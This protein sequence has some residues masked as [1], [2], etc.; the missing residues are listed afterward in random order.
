[1]SG[2]AVDLDRVRPSHQHKTHWA[3]RVNWVHIS[4]NAHLVPTSL[5]IY[6]FFRLLQ[7]QPCFSLCAC[8][9][10]CVRVHATSFYYLFPIGLPPEVSEAGNLSIGKKFGKKISEVGVADTWTSDV[11]VRR[12]HCLCC[13]CGCSRLLPHL[14]NCSLEGVVV[15]SFSSRYLVTVKD[16]GGGGGGGVAEA[17]EN[18]A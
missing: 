7:S 8:V 1:M 10:A 2:T 15:Q 4:V 9:C 11:T 3:T 13:L 6:L 14:D 5:C 18:F 16:G 12:V 17:G